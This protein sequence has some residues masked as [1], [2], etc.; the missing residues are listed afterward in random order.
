MS[1][2]RLSRPQGQSASGSIKSLKIPKDPIGNGTR[3]LPPWA[4]SLNE[5]TLWTTTVNGGAV[6]YTQLILLGVWGKKSAFEAGV[7]LTAEIVIPCSATVD[8]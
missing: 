3:N 8:S 4:Q 2:K 7:D 6:W 5:F 1:V